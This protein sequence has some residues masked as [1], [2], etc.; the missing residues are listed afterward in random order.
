MK[1][2][3]LLLA[4]IAGAF[5]VQFAATTFSQGNFTLRLFPAGT[6][7][8]SVYCFSSPCEKDQTIHF[9]MEEIYNSNYLYSP[10]EYAATLAN[11]RQGTTEFA[12]FLM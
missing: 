7:D 2:L 12:S 3:L 10:C 11:S 4:L 8:P 1:K 6:A 5:S 9:Y